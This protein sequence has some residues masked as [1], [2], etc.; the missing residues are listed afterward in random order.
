LAEE[1]LPDVLHVT[2][3]FEKTAVKP[4]FRFFGGVKLGEPVRRGEPLEHYHVVMHAVGTSDEN[5]LRI[6]GEERAGCHAATT[7]VAWYN[8]HP[9]ATDHAFDLSVDRA[10]V[11]GNA[12]VA[13]DVARMLVLHPDELAV[14][15]T[16]D[17]ESR[18]SRSRGRPSVRWCCWAGAGPAQAAFTNPELRELGG[19]MRAGV[20]VVP[21]DVALDPHSV[22]WLEEEA[23][24]TARWNSRS[25]SP[26]RRRDL[27]SRRIVCSR[28]SCVRRSRY[29]VRAP[30]SSDGRAG[31]QEPHRTGPAAHPTPSPWKGWQAID[32]AEKSAGQ[33]H[34]RP[35]IKLTR[36]PDL[37]AA[38]LT[39]D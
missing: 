34:G 31:S 3:V 18:R 15:D 22:G 38:S 6:P 2:P 32:I 23:D 7:F 12:N 28:G 9:D 36:V 24:A 10:V 17:H 30:W 19:V 20:R 13:I 35:R 39:K 1:T 27:V 26:T 16:A 5:R 11:I 29:S 25:C 8:G 14:T 33:P 4:G 37:V 21:A